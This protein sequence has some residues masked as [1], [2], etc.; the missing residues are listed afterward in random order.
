MFFYRRLG[1]YTSEH[2][3]GSLILGYCFGTDP[4]PKTYHFGYS[5]VFVP[6]ER[7]LAYPG[8]KP[9]GM[10]FQYPESPDGVRVSYGQPSGPE[11]KRGKNRHEM[12]V[13]V[14]I[15]SVRQPKGITVSETEIVLQQEF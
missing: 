1:S 9:R 11:E 4:L 8:Q 7:S 6:S 3:L 10:E 13:S 5:F 15:L 12:G 2:I 14:Y